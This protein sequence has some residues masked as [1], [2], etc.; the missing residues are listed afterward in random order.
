M[1]YKLNG[2]V[3]RDNIFH[4]IFNPGPPPYGMKAECRQFAIQTH[5]IDP[6]SP[7]Y[8]DELQQYM[9][10]NDTI[11]STLDSIIPG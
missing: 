9:N 11:V 1:P 5:H 10:E 3:V 7:R 4:T 6:I 2:G 8:G